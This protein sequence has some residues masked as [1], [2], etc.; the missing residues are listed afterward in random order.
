[1]DKKITPSLDNLELMYKNL[2]YWDNYT[3]SVLMFILVTITEIL[4]LLYFQVMAQ[5]QLIRNDWANQRCNPKIIPFAGFINS[6]NDI[7]NYTQENFEYC[8]QSILTDISQTAT[9]P[10]QFIVSTFS[11][12]TAAMEEDIQMIRAMFDKLRTMFQTIF[13]EIMGRLMNI[14]IPI[15]QI[16]ISFKDLVAKIEGTMTSALFLVLGAYYSLQSLCNDMAHIVVNILI[17][18]TVTIAILW[19]LPFTWVAAAALTVPYI[20]ITVIMAV[21]LAFM[22]DV[23]NLNANLTLPKLK[24]FDKNTLLMLNDGTSK[25]IIDITPGDILMNNNEVT[26]I[27]KVETKDSTIF[28]LNN[29]LVSDTHI[30]KYR[31]KWIPTAEHP[32]AVLVDSYNEPYLYCLNTSNKIIEI[33]NT[34]FTDWDEIYG[35]NLTILKKNNIIPINDLKDIHTYLDSGISAFTKINLKNK[36]CK[37]IKD[38]EIGDILENGG[39]VYGIVEINGK[40]IHKQYI[41]DLGETQSIKGGPNLMLINKNININKNTIICFDRKVL[42]K[43]EQENKL[44]HLLTDKKY[45]YINNIKIYDYN[46]SV[47]FFL[48]KLN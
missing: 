1:M 37:N 46:A 30:V 2:T 25:K 9:E 45:F 29:I 38:I 21:F 6:P 34:I 27:I 19:M 41:Y 16:I 47:D 35:E 48:D 33:N 24:C 13:Q 8:S 18:M 3:G 42:R 44:Y 20:I 43:E 17:G 14:M 7:I 26:S 22:V 23:L 28:N 31:E 39:R 15:Q 11:S 4:F 40:N 12:M 36:E 32:E 10:L 5:A